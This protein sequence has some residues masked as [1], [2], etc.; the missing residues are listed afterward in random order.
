MSRMIRGRRSQLPAGP[1]G[2]LNDAEVEQ[3]HEFLLDHG[4][5]VTNFD[6]LDGFITAIALLP[7]PMLSASWHP[8]IFGGA[9]GE[10]TTELVALAEDAGILALLVRHWAF[11]LRRVAFGGE[12]EIARSAEAPELGERRW[13]FGFLDGWDHLAEARPDLIGAEACAGLL[14]PIRRLIEVD[15]I[16]AG[17]LPPPLTPSERAE[18]NRQLVAG[19]N[20]LY[21]LFRV[22]RSG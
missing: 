13:A 17:L 12:W 14:A 3:L 10:E 7:E 16:R 9:G 1:G 2:P 19:V 18:V 15:Q 20:Q 11:V 6:M 8:Q 5:E 22:R 4:A 21:R